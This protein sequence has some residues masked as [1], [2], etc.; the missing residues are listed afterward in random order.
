MPSIAGPPRSGRASVRIF[1]TDGSASLLHF[2]P[3]FVGWCF[4][5]KRCVLEPKKMR[6]GHFFNPARICPPAGGHKK[7]C[8]KTNRSRALSRGNHQP[9]IHAPTP[10]ADPRSAR[11][12]LSA[13][14]SG[15]DESICP[16]PRPPASPGLLCSAPG[17]AAAPAAVLSAASLAVLAGRSLSAF[18]PQELAGGWADAPQGAGGRRP[19]MSGRAASTD[20]GNSTTSSPRHSAESRLLQNARAMEVPCDLSAPRLSGSLVR[21]RGWSYLC[22]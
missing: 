16:A 20:L 11:M 7:T 13:R 4:R 10:P 2:T 21:A 9:S 1:Q 15:A 8:K 6:P 18:D 14:H 12:A 17:C 3:L 5:A 22:Q 19:S